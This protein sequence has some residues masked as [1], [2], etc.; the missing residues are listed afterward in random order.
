M[1]RRVMLSFYISFYISVVFE[2]SRRDEST[3]AD[4]TRLISLVG[5]KNMKYE[6]VKAAA[7]AV[8]VVVHFG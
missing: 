2:V 5:L 1:K 4:H 3:S 7:M 8:L 6:W